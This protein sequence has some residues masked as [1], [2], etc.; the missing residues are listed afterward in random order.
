MVTVTLRCC[1][2][3]GIDSSYNTGY[4]KDNNDV[5]Q[6]IQFK[7]KIVWEKVISEMCVIY[8]QSRN[9]VLW[10]YDIDLLLTHYK[11]GKEYDLYRHGFEI[12]PE[13]EDLEEARKKYYTDDEIRK[14][15][16][17]LKAQYGN[18]IEGL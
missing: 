12:Q 1:T 17:A 16:K 15:K 14:Q 2:V 3:R 18:N 7:K 9:D 5:K 10:T 4:Y 13:K 11:Y 8:G 6:N